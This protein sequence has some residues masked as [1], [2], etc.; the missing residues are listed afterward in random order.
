MHDRTMTDDEKTAV[1]NAGW[2]MTD[3]L[4]A[5][6][7]ICAQQWNQWSSQKGRCVYIPCQAVTGEKFS[8][9]LLTAVRRCTKE[10][11]HSAEIMY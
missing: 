9:A 7:V 6:M 1:E 2:T 3:E 4:C 5:V 11:A 10:M 8:H